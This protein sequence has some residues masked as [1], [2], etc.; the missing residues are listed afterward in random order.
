MI[1][2]LST[3]QNIA[4]GHDSCHEDELWGKGNYILST[5][6]TWQSR[7]NAT[8]WRRFNLRQAR[9]ALSASLKPPKQVH[10]ISRSGAV[11]RH[12]FPA[13][14]DCRRIVLINTSR[15]DKDLPPLLFSTFSLCR[16]PR[17][18]QREEEE[19]EEERRRLLHTVLHNAVTQ[20][21]LP[22]S[23]SLIRMQPA[24][25][26]WAQQQWQEQRRRL[27]KRRWRPGQM[28]SLRS[29]S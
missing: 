3:Y 21:P 6:I 29:S 24:K 13:T 9:G 16:L 10:L 19:E 26:A 2:D 1:H 5:L 7:L 22:P 18:R 8:R 28:P 4:Y 14:H 12:G 11:M 20:P 25:E 23:N 17:Y 27:I 15:L